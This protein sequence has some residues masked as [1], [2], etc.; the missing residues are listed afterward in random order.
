MTRMLKNLVPL[1]LRHAVRSA[2]LRYPDAPFALAEEWY[3]ER[4]SR[5]RVLPDFVILGAQKCG[6]TSLYDYLCQ[7]PDVFATRIKEL[8]FFDNNFGRGL[9]WY[10][11]Y[12]PRA[13]EIEARRKA[14][15]TA[16]TGEASPNY[17]FHPYAAERIAAT[18]PHA[19]LI[20]ILRN[21][22]DRAYSHYQHQ[23]RYGREPLSFKD[24]L[25][26]E[27]ERLA[28]ED[29]ALRA[30]ELYVAQQRQYYSY[31]TRGR[32]VEQLTRW[33]DL[34]A[35]DQFLVLNFND[36]AARPGEVYG[37]VC[38]CLG[39]QPF[40]RVE[41]EKKNAGSYRPMDA[42]TRRELAA[43]YAPY[44]ARLYELLGEEFGWEGTE[45]VRA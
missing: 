1:G 9:D 33:L 38:A 5:E 2:V 6:T 45:S 27:E 20:V 25:A 17:F 30:D 22:V 8:H 24:A 37:R 13:A 23:V 11:T 14:G 28:P 35:R 21:P 29:A 10:R 3:R 12:F 19:R 32:Y 36:L 42:A 15:R 39:L 26:A 43:Y 16:C 31:R 41:F 34:L 44:N 4:T 18:L 40:T 7:H